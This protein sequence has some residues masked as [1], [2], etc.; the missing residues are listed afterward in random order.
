VIFLGQIL[1]K[2]KEKKKRIF[3]QK[4]SFYKENILQKKK[5]FVLEHLPKIITIAYNMKRHL[6]FLYFHI[7]SIAKF[8]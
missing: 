2:K 3:F 4:I 5:E 7:W 6:R 8:G 1:Q